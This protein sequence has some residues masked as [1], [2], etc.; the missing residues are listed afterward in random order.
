MVLNEMVEI[1][2]KSK[3]KLKTW[4]TKLG[5]TPEI[6]KPFFINWSLLKTTSYR[7]IKLKIKCDDCGA[8][9][10]KRICG[11]N[12]NIDYC[13]KC[14]NKGN[15]NGM[16]GVE[17]NENFIKAR[18]K[19]LEERGNPFT[20][21]STKQNNINKQV[22]KK[23]AKKNKGIKRSEETKKKLSESIKKAYKT[24]ILKPQNRWGKTII[25][26]YKGIDYQST[27]E[28]EFI[29]YCEKI[30]LF[31]MLERGPVIEYVDDNGL[32]H[33]YFSDFKIK[34]TNI[35]IEIKSS[36]MWQKNQRI[37]ELKKET[38]EKIY[39]YIVIKDNNFSEFDSLISQKI[40]NIVLD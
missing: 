23:I 21:D 38:S 20:W 29:K 4:E 24:G 15:R 3:L 12:G 13:F 34:N 32:T 30:G 36:Y 10:E 6:N 40:K 39:N 5:F 7:R 28:L 11:I 16:Y 18:N 25:K 22:W 17:P 8:A 33:N 19:M 26:Q 9:F 37:N 31:T 1:K 35:V 2:I 27:Y 14:M